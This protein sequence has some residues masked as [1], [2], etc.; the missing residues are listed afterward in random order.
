V[1]RIPKRRLTSRRF[2]ARSIL[3]S[4]KSTGDKPKRSYS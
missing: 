1:V 4:G 2:S 3:C